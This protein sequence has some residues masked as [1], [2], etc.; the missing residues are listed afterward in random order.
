[1]GDLTLAAREPCLLPDDFAERPPPLAC[2][3]LPPAVAERLAVGE[4]LTVALE[5]HR[6]YSE[7]AW[8]LGQLAQQQQLQQP[9]QAPQTATHAAPADR[10]EVGRLQVI[11][12]S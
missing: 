8:C 6:Q 4:G 1:M 11:P 3:P 2:D 10:Q 9:D 7:L 5:S 12:G